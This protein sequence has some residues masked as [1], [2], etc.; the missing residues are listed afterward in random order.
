MTKRSKRKLTLKQLEF[1]TEAVTKIKKWPAPT[2]DF[3]AASG[4]LEKTLASAVLDNTWDSSSLDEWAWDPYEQRFSFYVHSVFR[5]GE[6]I[7]SH[8]VQIKSRFHFDPKGDLLKELDRVSEEIEKYSNNLLLMQRA[9]HDARK[10]GDA[11]SLSP[12]D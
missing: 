3:E 5:M 4:M 6:T 11:H 1:A 10:A 8:A 2:G 9:Y 7:S 12:D